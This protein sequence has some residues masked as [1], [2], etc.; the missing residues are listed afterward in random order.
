VLHTRMSAHRRQRHV[1]TLR[2]AT[3]AKISSL[4]R[5]QRRNTGVRSGMKSLAQRRSE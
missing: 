3:R 4:S 5:Y 2:S 1:H